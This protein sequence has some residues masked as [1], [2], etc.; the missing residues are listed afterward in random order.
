MTKFDR[1][2]VLYYFN[3][4]KK[5]ICSANGNG[6]DSPTIFNEE[7]FQKHLTEGFEFFYDYVINK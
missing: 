6:F 3:F 5:S 1:I 7:I 2:N 4:S